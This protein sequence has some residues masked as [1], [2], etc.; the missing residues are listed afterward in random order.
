MQ[1]ETGRRIGRFQIAATLGTGGFAT[2]YRA[3]DT[4]LRREV[5][6]KLLHPQLA[7]DE[8]F[9]RRFAAEAQTS[10]RLR[11]PHIVTVYEV[12]ETEEGHPY[13]VMELL[14]GEPLSQVIAKHGPFA[15]DQ[16]SR[17]LLQLSAALDYLHGQGLIHRDLKPSNVMVD[18]SGDITLMDFG[19]ARALDEQAHLTQTGQLVGSPA[20][21]AP[22]QIK[23]LPVSTA[24]DLYALGIL[25]YELLA[26]RTPFRGNVTSV[27]RAQ[28]DTPPPPIGEFNPSLPASAV[29][30]LDSILAKEPSQRP[31]SAT[32]FV[33]LLLGE[34]SLDSVPPEAHG[35]RRGTLRP[36]APPS[37]DSPTVVF[38]PTVAETPAPSVEAAG[39]RP[40]LWL[41]SG[42]VGA[43]AAAGVLIWLFLAGPLAGGNG[44]LAV[45][46]NPSGATVSVDGANLGVTPLAA[47]AL[48][49][50]TYTLVVDKPGYSEAARTEKIS[51]RETTTEQIQLSSLPIVDQIDVLNDPNHEFFAT[52]VTVDASGVVQYGTKISQVTPQQAFGL[53]VS[54]AQKFPGQRDLA[55]QYQFKIVDAVG[56]LIGEDTLKDGTI[57]KDVT[58]DKPLPLYWSY[59][60]PVSPDGNVRTGVYYVKLEIDGE[61]VASQPIELTK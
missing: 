2:V 48:K 53:I 18:D 59:S 21:L 28:L 36:P 38:T 46:S 47:H 17:I 6:I 31:P 43:A 55:F 60:F 24:S 1:P 29:R 49:P 15:L 27:I 13:L 42:A 4:R 19:I 16:A 3:E 35:G 32:A 51:A 30:A 37:P 33:R 56:D 34:T 12:G 45:T 9:V 20:Y 41:I 52:N 57:A 14:Q 26:G 10:A 8:G 5:A 7:A 50:G 22:E 44:R 54:L 11:H 25:T 58:V 23:G 40:L 39:R 61:E